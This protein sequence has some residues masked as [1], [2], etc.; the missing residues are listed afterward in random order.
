MRRVGDEC[1]LVL[2]CP[3]QPFEEL[4]ERRDER[5]DL[6]R[7]WRRR[8][9]IEYAR[10]PRLDGRREFPERLE[11]PPD[12]PPDEQRERRHHHA[13]GCKRP[14]RE[15][16]SAFLARAQRLSDLDDV[17]PCDHAEDPPAAAGHIDRVESEGR[18]PRQHDLRLR[19]V[20][21]TPVERPDL[22]D[23]IV[24]R[25]LL[26]QPGLRRETVGLVPEEQ[27]RLAQV[28]VEELVRLGERVPV[29]HESTGDAHDEYRA[30]QPGQQSCAQGVHSAGGTR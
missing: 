21:A 14:E 12:R 9:R 17:T 19:H 4:V 13:E 5:L 23:E 30:E 7:Q 28:F 22:H 24:L 16:R 8:Q 20:D 26:R 3:A 2:E 29:E 27:R 18:R 25:H 1:A 10:P 11:G 6:L 15:P